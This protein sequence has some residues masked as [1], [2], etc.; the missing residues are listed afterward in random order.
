MPAN[1]RPA[2]PT[3]CSS[4]SSRWLSASTPPPSVPPYGEISVSHGV[5]SANSRSRSGTPLTLTSRSAD[6]SVPAK[7][8]W[9]S[10]AAQIRS[11]AANATVHC[12]SIRNAAPGSKCSSPTYVAPVVRQP[13]N[14]RIEARW[15]IGSGSHIRSPW[16]IGNR[17][18]PKIR[19]V[20]TSDSCEITQPFG[21]EV[22]PDVYMIIA[23]SRGFVS[24]SSPPADS[25]SRTSSFIPACST[26]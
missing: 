25:S 10:T 13:L 15:K 20:R 21:C 23:G 5:R 6:R 7:S 1:G 26:T 17:C 4:G 8:G 9:S 3:R 24:T 12:S 2:E 11:K 19:P 22:V 14:G 16:R 18:S